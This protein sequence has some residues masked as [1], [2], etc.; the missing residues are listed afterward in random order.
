MSCSTRTIFLIPLESASNDRMP[1]PEKRSNDDLHLSRLITLNKL[2]LINA[3]VGLRFGLFG[4]DIFLDLYCPEIIF[5]L[6]FNRLAH[7]HYRN[8]FKIN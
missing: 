5:S 7:R 8:I 3:F 6:L 4:I 1:L 2:S